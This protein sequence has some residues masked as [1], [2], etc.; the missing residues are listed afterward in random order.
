MSKIKISELA[1][2]LEIEAKELVSYLQD[3][4]V[5]AAKRSTSS[6]DEEDAT[7]VK[8]HFGKGVNKDSKTEEKNEKAE[9]TEVKSEDKKPSGEQP[10]KK[11]KNIIFV[12]NPNNSRNGGFKNNGGNDNNRNNSNN[13]NNNQRR[14]NSNSNNGNNR[15]N[16]GMFAQSQNAY[17]PIKPKTAP[18]QLESYDTVITKSVQPSSKPAVK[19]NQTVEA[20]EPVNTPVETTVNTENTQNVQEVKTQEVKSQD[21]R[22]QDNRNQDN[23]SQDNRN[24]DNRSQDNRNQDRRSDNR[25]NGYRN[26]NNRNQN[27]DR[28]FNRSDRN[29]QGDR[30]FNR[31]DRN[32]QG[33]R[34]FNR[35]DRNGQG[36]RNFNRSDRN[37]QGDR[38]F[39]RSDRNGQGGGFNRNGQSGF[40]GRPSFNKDDNGGRQ[41]GFGNRNSQN[42]FSK[43]PKNSDDAPM[44]PAENKRDDKRRL[45]QEKDKRNKKDLA[46]EDEENMP[47]SKKVGRFIKP[48]VKKVEE[49]EEQ[50]KVI[51]IPEKLTIKEL[52][53]KMKMQPSVIIKKLFMAGQITTVNTE[54]SYE[55]AEN[56]AIDYE[57]ICEKEIPVDVIEELLKEDDDAEDTLEKRPPVVCVMGHVD[58]GKTSLL[59]AIRKTS[60]TAKEAGGIT[61][62]I[63]A[64]TVSVNDQSITFL[65]TP[66][67]EA[68]TAMRMRGA[69]STDIAVLVV[70][71]D[72]GVMPQT[73]EAIN[74]AKAAEVEIIVAVNKIDKPNANIDRVKQEMTEHGLIATDW[75]G[76]TEFVPVSAKTGEG[77]DTLLETVLLTAEILELKANPNRQA[78]GLV[79]EAKLDKGRG[80]VAN[81]LIQK[82]T[83]H[84]GDFI[85][86]GASSGKVR[87]MVDDKGRRLKEAL[88]SQ[89]VEILGLS[90]VPN[91]GEVLVG[92]ESD[93]E[94]KQYANTYLQQHKK[95]LIEETKAKMSL[96]D[97]YSKI[98]E[99][100]LQ[101]LEIIIK[102]DVQGSAEALKQSL[103]KLSNDEV[104]VKVIHCGVGAINESDVTLASAS[105]AI[106]IGF[107]VRPDATAKS[108][109][110]REGVEI[111]LY[112]VIY[113]AIEDVDA[114]M[115]GMLAPVYEEK[116][117]GHAEIRQIFKASKVGNIAGAMVLDGMIQKDCK[118]RVSREGEQIFEGDLAS[119]KR[120]KDDVK[121]VKEGY[122]CG[123]VFDGFDQIHELDQVEAY[124]MVEVPRE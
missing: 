17:H 10:V 3:Q 38:N 41:A 29:G 72:D 102:A 113:Q 56:I 1:K 78:R 111:K 95:D 83:L 14:Q 65:D 26:D 54:L 20:K 2:E 86:A 107:D 45:S 53:E 46:Y 42:K 80:P 99:G 108:I 48:E 34:N 40:G 71:A 24:Q 9:K 58:H 39:N 62:K 37:G 94:A 13:G 23:R 55:E 109:A 15:N 90:D 74:H 75:G 114:A 77:I 82:G 51:T 43:G 87:A 104:V 110:E 69:K 116:V 101:D 115:K 49:P 18:S 122:E 59:D 6:I 32:G 67:H 88:P 98:E 79:L 7:K 8:K 68:F 91:A 92:H 31:S 57:I 19:D 52:A 27:G 66:G 44:I 5:E 124:I 50:I 28:N 36:D 16:R 22:N 21:N 73:I 120:F 118:V 93:K 121:E 64:Y 85:S 35:S 100:K 96:D 105:N 117:I 76:Q 63:G 60:V 112:K 12:T 4:G 84:V 70:A 106:I 11:K 81:I 47:R 30:N 61:Q 119:L 33:D 103:M 89:P 123:L 25:N 97:L